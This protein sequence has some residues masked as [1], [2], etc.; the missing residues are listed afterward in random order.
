MGYQLFEEYKNY[1]HP[2]N[3]MPTKLGRIPRPMEF[4]TSNRSSEFTLMPDFVDWRKQ[5]AVTS[6]RD[7]GL[8]CGSCWAFSAVSFF[9]FF[10]YK[11]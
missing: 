7:Q 5:G 9:Y 11:I 2:Q 1:M 8:I 10:T 6:V 3:K 4:K